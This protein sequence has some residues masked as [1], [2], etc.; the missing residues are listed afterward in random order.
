MRVISGGMRIMVTEQFIIMMVI[1]ISGF[2]QLILVFKA[3]L[4]RALKVFLGKVVLRV[5][6]VFLVQSVE[7]TVFLIMIT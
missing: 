5:F 7:T 4:D 6:K 3:L 1:A 2:L